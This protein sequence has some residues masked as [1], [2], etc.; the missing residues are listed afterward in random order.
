MRLAAWAVPILHDGRPLPAAIICGGALLREPD[1]ALMDHV[2]SVAEREGVD[3]VELVRSLESV[4]VIPRERLRA[5]A[6]FLFQMSAAVSVFPVSEDLLADA[7]SQAEPAEVEPSA[8]SS[9]ARR[10]ES[11]KAKLQRA[12]T[13]E[14]QSVEGE[15]VRLLRERK[16]GA[17]LDMLTELM[18]GENERASGRGG[19][20]SLEAAETFTRLFKTLAGDE[21]IPR[22]IYDKQSL[23]VAS[24]LSHRNAPAPL[25]VIERSCRKFISIAEELTGPSRP[26]QVKAIQKYL[27]K[28]L[29]R[30]LTLGAVGKKF[31]LKEKPLDALVRK[32]CGVPFTDYVASLR[33]SEAKRL[34]LATD[35]SMGEIARKT[36]FKDQ[37]YFTKVFKSNIGSTPTEFRSKKEK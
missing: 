26:R 25:D 13:L 18:K 29:S 9:R 24:A 16:P 6:D 28:N 27:E 37:S 22:G 33:V 4:P 34:L 1:S 8:V 3:P 35:M 17:A 2:K 11:K 36:G 32:H 30:K 7:E 23:L 21:R 15:I 12:R 19:A 31:G 10:K 14:R 5:I 20:V